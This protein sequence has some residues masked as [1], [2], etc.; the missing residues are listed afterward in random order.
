MLELPA[1]EALFVLKNSDHWAVEASKD[2]DSPVSVRVFSYEKNMVHAFSFFEKAKDV[3][4]VSKQVKDQ[5]CRIERIQKTAAGI[6]A[7]VECKI[8]PMDLAM[9]AIS[10]KTHSRLWIKSNPDD[11]IYVYVQNPWKVDFKK[12]VLP[13][14]K[15]Y[16]LQLAY[17]PTVKQIRM[18]VPIPNET[19]STSPVIDEE[20]KIIASTLLA[21]GYYSSPR[22]KGL[23]LDVLRK[24]L[25]QKKLNV[26]I[27]K[28]TLL[29]RMAKIE[30]LGIQKL[31]E[32]APFSDKTKQASLKIF[33]EYI[34]GKSKKR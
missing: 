12:E 31:F 9:K 6:I 25:K 28:P 30:S 34:K 16:K 5:H 23:T 7:G 33:Q 15:K 18:K 21:E 32:A 24:K 2:L 14:F 19:E 27:S 4:F 26:D 1:Q 22:P 10:E 11:L 17:T 29:K 20:D 3:K 8:S 13:I